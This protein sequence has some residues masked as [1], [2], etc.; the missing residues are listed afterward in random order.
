MTP[1]RVA[2]ADDEPLARKRLARLLDA[3]QDVELAGAFESADAL[4]ADLAELDVDVLLLDVRMPG[5]SG[6]DARSLLPD[7]GPPVILVSAHPEHALAA[8]EVGVLDYV[9]KPVDAARLAKALDRVR[10]QG[11]SASVE[12]LALETRDGLLLLDPG[13]ITHVTLANELAHV[14]TTR[15][16]VLV[17][18]RTLG[19]LEARIPG[20][21][22][23][24]RTALLLLAH[25]ERL[26]DNG[27]GG[28]EA[29]V[30]GGACVTVSRQ[31]ARRMRRRWNV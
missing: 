10:A 1:L 28:Y 4:L 25:V 7:D 19:D 18:E 14:H 27:T 21:L 26:V 11:A 12:R 9:P 3:M 15:G 24:H 5:L 17:S 29:H 22:R 16:E 13:E 30:V 2:L 8:F 20:A 23:V 31:A 6:L